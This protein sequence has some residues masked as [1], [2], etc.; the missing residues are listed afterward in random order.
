MEKTIR[1][2]VAVISFFAFI[3]ITAKGE[4]LYWTGK[5]SS[6][7]SLTSLNW[8]NSSG[9]ASA[10]IDGSSAELAPDRSLELTVKGAPEVANFS[11]RRKQPVTLSG[12][13][14]IVFV[15]ES[16]TATNILRTAESSDLIFEVPVTNNI[17][18]LKKTGYGIVYFRS[19]SS[20][21][22]KSFIVA[23]NQVRINGDRSLGPGDIV[24]SGSSSLFTEAGTAADVE[25]KFVQSYGTYLGSLSHS[26]KLVLRSVGT[27]DGDAT[28]T[29]GFGRSSGGA[30][31]AVLSLT[32]VSSEAIGTYAIRGNFRLA[33]DG[34]CVKSSPMSGETL[35]KAMDNYWSRTLFVSENG[36]TF[37][38]NGVETELGAALQFA[39]TG[40]EIAK[41]A[42]FENNSFEDDAASAALQGWTIVK[43]DNSGVDSMVTENG[44]AFTQ[45]NDN[46]RQSEYY[47]TAGTR[48]FVL[49]SNHEATRSFSLPEAGYW[50]VSFWRGCRPHTGYPS[51][52]LSLT[53]IVDGD[54]RLSTS[55]AP[56]SSIYSFRNDKT[57][58]F[59]LAAGEHSVT[60]KVGAKTVSD[61][62]AIFLDEISFERVENTDGR[63][64]VAKTGEGML[65]VTNLPSEA[66]ALVSGGT[67]K[68]RAAQVEGAAVEVNSGAMLALAGSKLAGASINVHSNAALRI[69]SGNGE[70]IVKNG[71]F[72][73]DAK[74]LRVSTYYA[75]DPDGWTMAY[76]GTST[77]STRNSGIQRDGG[78]ITSA[79]PYSPFGMVTAY[80]REETTMSQTITIPE[81]GD[82]RFS[83]IQASRI[84]SGVTSFKIPLWVELDGKTVISNAAQNANYDYFESATNLTLSAGE[85]LLKFKTGY[86]NNISA[87]LFIDNVRIES[88]APENDLREARVSLSSGSTL[89]LDN[90]KELRIAKN[91]VT[92]DGNAVEKGDAG[93]LAALGVNIEG[94][95]KISIGAANGFMIILR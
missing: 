35:F 20:E 44:S 84:R 81:D 34:G 80:M 33:L 14:A 88:L 58:A 54:E 60:F 51:Y 76:N 69:L 72:E 30:S 74:D 57:E 87:M 47:T 56:E 78:T 23:E 15:A 94:E 13:G 38:V 19:Q 70:N 18:P 62:Q 9:V 91:G 79:G 28:R 77:D 21:F 66:V 55:W 46:S 12:D 8:T 82:Y 86:H 63:F 39:E 40:T 73:N 48:F 68:I 37:D 67:L 41:T 64:I 7:W 10:W 26:D 61:S 27:G 1:R 59:L 95:G 52:S 4:T 83:F 32:N 5:E 43:K 31:A 16:E 22:G 24:L 42:A 11:I 29:F 53:V 90:A 50:R 17:A 25:A 93:K 45:D 89:V 75:M 49:R 6:E 2:G 71:S 36:V 3:A 92:V 85:H 65:A